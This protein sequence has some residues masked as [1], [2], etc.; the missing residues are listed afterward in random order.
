[1]AGSYVLPLQL[2]PPT[3]AR[4]AILRC[5]GATSFMLTVRTPEKGTAGAE[6][7]LAG[8]VFYQL[9]TGTGTAP[10]WEASPRLCLPGT[11][12]RG[13]PCDAIRVWSAATD[14]P[15][16]IQLEADS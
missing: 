10:Q 5:A 8:G 14:A 3:Q 4:G 7:G 11:L 12:V 1:V 9:G 16:F 2:S 13:L 6:A 15:Q